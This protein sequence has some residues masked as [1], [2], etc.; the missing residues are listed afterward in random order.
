LS[1]TLQRAK[2]RDYCKGRFQVHES[3]LAS[4][5]RQDQRLAGPAGSGP[6]HSIC[7]AELQH[8]QK[9]ALAQPPEQQQ[10][11]GPEQLQQRASSPFT[12]AT[13][14]ADNKQTVPGT[15]VSPA[16]S[17]V[18]LLEASGLQPRSAGNSP[19][20]SKVRTRTAGSSGGSGGAGSSGCLSDGGGSITPT[21]AAAA[22][23]SS[24]G[25]AAAAAAAAVVQQRGR[26]TVR[27]ESRPSSRPSSAHG[28]KAGSPHGSAHHPGLSKLGSK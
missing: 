19:L 12:L 11:T 13:G 9:Q 10:V 1:P 2:S 8:L 6:S 18:Q 27:Q 28:S 16:A 4:H 26:F 21:A 5:V 25:Q 14:A 24:D 23:S 20:M 22:A 3:P 7:V 15:A 17:A